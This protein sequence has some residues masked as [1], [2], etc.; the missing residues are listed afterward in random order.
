M[1]V[2]G[3][4][5]LFLADVGNGALVFS[6]PGQSGLYRLPFVQPRT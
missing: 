1:S 5:Y 4:I 3:V 6:V 2:I